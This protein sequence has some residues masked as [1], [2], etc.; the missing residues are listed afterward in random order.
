MAPKV[1]PITITAEQAA[2]G[3]DL[4]VQGSGISATFQIPPCRDGDLVPAYLAGNEVRLRIVIVKERSRPNAAIGRFLGAFA[5]IAAV[6]GVIVVL[7][8]R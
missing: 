7:V 8:Q 2:T 1:I 6:A 5:V 4:P 3:V